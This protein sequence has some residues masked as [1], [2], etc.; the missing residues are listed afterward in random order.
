MCI[1]D[2]LILLH[3]LGHI[4]AVDTHGHDQ[5][6]VRQILGVHIDMDARDVAQAGG[7]MCIRDR[8]KPYGGFTVL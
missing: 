4:H 8:S 1:R 5:V 6:T 3:T 2:S 7:Q